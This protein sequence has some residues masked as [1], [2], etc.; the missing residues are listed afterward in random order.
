MK[1]FLFAAM[2]ILA[3]PMCVHAQT[4]T[5]ATASVSFGNNSWSGVTIPGGLQSDGVTLFTGMKQAA[6][7]APFCPTW[8]ELWDGRGI[9]DGQAVGWIMDVPQGPGHYHVVYQGTFHVTWNWALW[10][11][12][13]SITYGATVSYVAGG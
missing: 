9:D 4:T 13:W 2:T 8:V 5:Y 6:S 7:V 10:S 11:Y 12:Q 3:S 1:R